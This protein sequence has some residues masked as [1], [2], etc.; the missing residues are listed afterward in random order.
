MLKAMLA[1]IVIAAVSGAVTADAEAAQTR[2]K[3]KRT[4]DSQQS[5]RRVA[6]AARADRAQDRAQ[7]SS[8]TALRDRSTYYHANGRLNG[9]EFFEQLNERNTGAGE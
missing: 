1:A 4:A 6:V 8:P 3:A 2:A 5:P 7:N 9:R